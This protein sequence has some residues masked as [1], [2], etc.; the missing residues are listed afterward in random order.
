MDST[1]DFSDVGG[2]Q[3]EFLIDGKLQVALGSDIILTPLNV[4]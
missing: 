3:N 2:V 4:R 1:R